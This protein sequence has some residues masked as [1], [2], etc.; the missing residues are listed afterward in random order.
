M[1]NLLRSLREKNIG[2]EMREV[3]E[4][5]HRFENGFGPPEDLPLRFDVVWGTD[6]LMEWLNPRSD[7][8]LINSLYGHI[9][10][11]GL[12]E[13]AEVNGTLEL[14]YFFEFKIRYRFEF[15][16]N[17]KVYVYTGEKVNIKPWNLPVSHTTCFGTIVEKDTNIL[18]SRSV[19]FFKFSR[20]PSFLLSLRIKSG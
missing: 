12:C 5:S 13:N 9:T 19:V 11:V 18:I 7:R 14:R 16:A 20:I 6:N 8:F 4:G 15:E 17:K 1:L 2:F 10:A 3:M